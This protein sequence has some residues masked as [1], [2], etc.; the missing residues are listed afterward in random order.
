MRLLIITQ[1]VDS[2]DPVLGFFHEWITE[3]AKHFEYIEVV[4]LREGSYG[5]PKNVHVQSLGK[6]NGR[7][8]RLIY[9]M[10]FYRQIW[11]LR[12]QYDAVFVHMN[13]EYVILGGLFWLL[14]KRPVVLWYVHQ[15]A[16]IRLRLSM[17]FM[18]AVCSATQHTFPLST[19]K[20]R[21]TGHGINLSLFTKYPITKGGN[22]QCKWVSVGRI[23]SSKGLETLIQGFALFSTTRSNAILDLIGEA[24]TE[25]DHEYLRTLKSLINKLMLED[26]ITFTGSVTQQ[27]L[28][29]YLAR[30][31]LFVS[32][33][34][35][36]GV[37]K[38]VLEAMATGL[39]TLVSNKVFTPYFEK[40]PAQC[41][42][43]ENDPGD[44]AQMAHQLLTRT[45]TL[46]IRAGLRSQV[47]ERASLE[48]VIRNISHTFNRVPRGQ[49]C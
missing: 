8:S 48:T 24:V 21:V 35:T 36:G 28:P 37:D 34:K 2:K 41:M 30:Y 7:V 11:R 42:Y 4:C 15:H 14:Q 46:Q 23:S 39:L 10:R 9:M 5:F 47:Q 3:F 27:E 49:I 12:N 43:R 22:A 38:A 19:K 45:D 25:A 1:I 40:I 26:R 17:P 29:S 6:E 18:T 16:G 32:A 20:L 33:S 31:D 44:L 13:P